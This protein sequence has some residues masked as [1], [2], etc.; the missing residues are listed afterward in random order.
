MT[1]RHA[2]TQASDIAN[3]PPHLLESTATKIF[4]VAKVLPSS[5]K[6][7]LKKKKSNTC[8]CLMAGLS[9]QV[10]LKISNLE[11]DQFLFTINYC[12]KKQ[13]KTI[14]MPQSLTAVTSAYPELS[15]LGTPLIVQL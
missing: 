5:D 8:G 10:C 9:L 3:H 15:F 11:F 6:S 13:Q 1:Q 14:T 12:L 2:Q 4:L 7:Q